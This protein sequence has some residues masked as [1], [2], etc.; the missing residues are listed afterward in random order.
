MINQELSLVGPER[1]FR[2]LSGAFVRKKK[3]WTSVYLRSIYQ[4]LSFKAS[5]SQTQVFLSNKS[6]LSLNKSCVQKTL[7]QLTPDNSSHAFIVV[8]N[9]FRSY[10]EMLMRLLLKCNK[11]NVSLSLSLHLELAPH[12]TTYDTKWIK[13]H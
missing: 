9:T 5:K 13:Y 2:G 8:S 11:M 6:C 4:E 10:M 1:A 12:L 3:L 7:P